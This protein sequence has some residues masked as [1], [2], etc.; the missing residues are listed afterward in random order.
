MNWINLINWKK[1]ETKKDLIKENIFIIE[2]EEIKEELKNVDDIKEREINI[3]GV[4][5]WKEK[6]KSY[7]TIKIAAMVD[8]IYRKFKSEII[9]NKNDKRNYKFEEVTK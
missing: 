1:I 5:I 6:N 3:I 2:I 4:T 7:W 9:E 8:G